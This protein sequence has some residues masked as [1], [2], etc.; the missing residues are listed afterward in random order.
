MDH[1]AHKTAIRSYLVVGAPDICFWFSRNRMKA[2][3]TKGLFDDISDLFAR[4]NYKS[5][6]GD[7]D[8]GRRFRLG[9]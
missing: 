2:F 5:V 8:R 1:E 4:E 3:V 7:G 6:L 9:L